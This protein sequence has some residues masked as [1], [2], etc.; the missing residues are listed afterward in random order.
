MTL[1]CD[2][3]DICL[4]WAH[5]MKGDTCT[6]E[7]KP[8]TSVTYDVTDW[9]WATFTCCVNVAYVTNSHSW[10]APFSA[11]STVLTCF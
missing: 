11:I 9:I 4:N 1:K 3:S 8:H 6:K 5:F 7:H 10:L 2:I